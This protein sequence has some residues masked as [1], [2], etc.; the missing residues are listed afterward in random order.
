MNLIYLVYLYY[1]DSKLFDNILLKIL[2]D[3]KDVINYLLST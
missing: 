1:Y 3:V 2:E